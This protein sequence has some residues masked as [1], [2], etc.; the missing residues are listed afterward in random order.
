MRTLLVTA[1]V[2]V[3]FLALAAPAS[4]GCEVSHRPFC[5]CGGPPDLRDPLEYFTRVCPD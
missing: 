1:L 5:D 4:A 2:A 3:P